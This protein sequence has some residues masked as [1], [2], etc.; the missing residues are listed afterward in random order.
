MSRLRRLLRVLTTTWRYSRMAQCHSDRV[1]S[2]TKRWASQIL[3]LFDVRLVVKG[4]PAGGGVIFVGNHI[5]YLDIPLLMSKAAVNFLAKKELASWPIF[6]T[7]MKSVGTLFVDR[8]SKQSRA[9]VGDQMA[10]A[11]RET[12]RSIGIFPSGTTTIDEAVPWRYGIFVTAKRH[13]IPIQPFRLTYSPLRKAAYI[14]K[15]SFMPHLWE[16]LKH[17]VEAR[18]EFLEPRAVTDPQGECAE[19][20]QWAKQGV[21]P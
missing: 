3:H 8:S 13:R 11:F 17:P 6:G 4:T 10:K 21:C 5:S 9:R 18:L 12:G 16:L 14:G 7:A 19:L 20:W 15:D 1:P 2:V